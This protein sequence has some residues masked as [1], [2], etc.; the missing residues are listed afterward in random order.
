[1]S[2]VQANMH[3]LDNYLRTERLPHVWCSG[4]GIGTVLGA[5]LRA[6]KNIGMDPEKTIMVSG[7]G[8]TGRAAGY[9][10]MDSFHTTH[11]RPIPFAVGIKAARP[12]LNVTVFSGDGDLFAIGGNHIIHAARR[13]AD[14]TVITINNF[15]YGMTGGQLAPTTPETGI[16]TTSPYGNV[17]SPFNLAGLVAVSGASYVARW[18]S[19]HVRRLEKSIEKALKK[20]GFSFVEVLSPCPTAY[21]RRNRMRDPVDMLKYFQEHAVVKHH[22]N[23]LEGVIEPDKDFIVGEFLDAEEEPTFEDKLWEMTKKEFLYT[24]QAERTAW[25]LEHRRHLETLSK[26]ISGRGER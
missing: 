26:I 9:V 1:M 17:E 25:I 15:I 6:M 8:C 13:N 22:I 3:P 18:T 19:L 12:D 20:R 21:G 4:C 16:T 23:P 14:I 7:I 11:G 5:Y 10:K 24:S 2:V